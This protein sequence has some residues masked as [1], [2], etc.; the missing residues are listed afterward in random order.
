ML[1]LLLELLQLSLL[2]ANHL[3]QA[4]L[5][6]IHTL[7]YA[8][9]SLGKKKTKQMKYPPPGLPAP[10]LIP[11]VTPPEKGLFGGADPQSQRPGYPRDW[12]DWPCGMHGR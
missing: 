11:D 4:V 12:W 9:L 7:A 6:H 5:S 3:Q 2:G 10:A 1:V 8:S